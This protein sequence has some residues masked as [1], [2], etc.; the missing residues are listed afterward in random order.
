[1][2]VREGGR[3]VGLYLPS[4]LC[5]TCTNCV[6]LVAIVGEEVSVGFPLQDTCRTSPRGKMQL[7]VYNKDICTITSDITSLYE[8]RN[9][10]SEIDYHCCLYF[11]RIKQTNLLSPFTLQYIF[12]IILSS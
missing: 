8:T 12:N 10:I 6:A 4:C 3:G 11:M 7:T 2:G 1:V 5:C 9:F